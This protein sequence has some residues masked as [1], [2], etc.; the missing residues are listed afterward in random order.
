MT[1]WAKDFKKQIERLK[2]QEASKKRA[3]EAHKKAQAEKAADE[4]LKALKEKP[5]SD[6]KGGE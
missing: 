3:F 1:L 6:E 2:Q 4:V 5:P